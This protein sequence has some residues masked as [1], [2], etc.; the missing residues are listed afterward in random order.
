[1]LSPKLAKFSSLPSISRCLVMA[2]IFAAVTFSTTVAVAD[3]GALADVEAEQRAIFEKVA[4]AVVFLTHGEG[5]GSGFF[6]SSHG[7]ILTN[8]HVVEDYDDV[9][10]VLHDGRQKRGVVV[11]RYEPM[12]LA[13]VTIDVDDSPAVELAPMD[14]VQVGDWVASVGHGA[15]AVW[16][17]TFGMISNIYPDGDERPVFQTQIPLN[18]G[19]SG[20]PV[21]DRRGRVLGIVTFGIAGAE[22]LNFAVPVEQAVFYLEELATRCDCLVVEAPDNIPI[23]VDDVMVGTGPRVVVMAEEREYEVMAIIDGQRRAE[24]IRW[25]ETRTLTLGD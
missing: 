2:A 4:P 6:V 23:Y 15:G 21:V 13:I 1:M 20:G 9:E 10:V 18:P 7:D 8:A 19:N 3:S 17:F 5:L 12:D 14:R 11:E 22:N 25:P 16:S 24:T